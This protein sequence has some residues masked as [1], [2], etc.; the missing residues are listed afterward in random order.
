VRYAKDYQ[1]NVK[2]GC[3]LYSTLPLE[4]IFEEL[5]EFLFDKTYNFDMAPKKFKMTVSLCTEEEIDD[6]HVKVTIELLKMPEGR[7]C[8]EFK[9]AAGDPFEYF[10]KFEELRQELLFI[11]EAV[12]T[13]MK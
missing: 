7:V 6:D 11:T 12:T 3:E 8:I 4:D 9:R 13:E 10:E 1:A 2:S 5:Q